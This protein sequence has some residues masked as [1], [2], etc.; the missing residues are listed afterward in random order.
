MNEPPSKP[1]QGRRL[2]NLIAAACLL[3]T[4]MTPVHTASYVEGGFSS[5]PI[6]LPIVNNQYNPGMFV[7]NRNQPAFDIC[8]LPSKYDMQLWWNQSPYRTIGIYLGGSV[9]ANCGGWTL[10]REWLTAADQ[11]G[12]TFIPIWVGPQPLSFYNTVPEDPGKIISGDIGTAYLQGRS[13]ANAAVAKARELG[14]QN[15]L[16]IYYN[17]EPYR[18]TDYEVS[19]S[20]RD[21]T[22]SFISGWVAQMHDTGNKAGVYGAPINSFM[23]DWTRIVDVP[24]DVWTADWYRN[25]SG[26]DPTITVWDCECLDGFWI[27]H[28]RIYQYVG[29]VNETWGNNT[30]RI[31]VDVVDGEITAF[32]PQGISATPK[33]GQISV[34]SMII[35]SPHIQDSQLIR[36]DRGWVLVEGRLFWLDGNSGK[37]IS[38]AISPA[39]LVK[40]AFFLDDLQGWTVVV[41]ESR[42]HYQLFATTDGGLNWKELSFPK[43]DLIGWQPI[44]RLEIEFSQMGTGWLSIQF[45][46]NRIARKVRLYRTTDGGAS[47][48]T[49]ST[50][51]AGQVKFVDDNIGWLVA[52]NGREW[53]KTVDGGKTW[54]GESLPGVTVNETGELRIDLPVFDDLGG[55]ILPVVSGQ[56]GRYALSVFTTDPGGQS[57]RWAASTNLALPSIGGTPFPISA[58]GEG[59]WIIALPDGS[60]Q[61]ITQAQDGELAISAAAG[62]LPGGVT[63]L[64]FI[65]VSKGWA[66]VQLGSC[67]GDKLNGPFTCQQS[68]AL[69]RT[70]DGGASWAITYQP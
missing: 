14:F 11:L 37:D 50:S 2:A 67:M 8:A 12:W 62:H 33:P 26:Y 7:I 20:E 10:N 6:Y 63:S 18:R 22:A 13:E 40:D 34:S 68:S 35:S 36:G 52:D 60:L 41:D 69:Y 4:S 59:Q 17:V 3:L 48:G 31:D 30:M 46:G 55:V 53:F 1:R 65:D 42:G 25:K 19:Q 56:P 16:I 47:W 45:G 66:T 70:E 15:D 32:G 43:D 61:A 49:S 23:S 5:G 58:A 64:Q 28:Q 38:P 21:A 39:S 29:E 9:K 57:W 24:D 44:S 27:N 54:T 51:A